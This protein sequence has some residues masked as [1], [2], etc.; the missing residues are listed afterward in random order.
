MSNYHDKRDR[1]FKPTLLGFVSLM[2]ACGTAHL[3]ADTKALTFNTPTLVGSAAPASSAV[4]KNEQPTSAPPVKTSTDPSNAPPPPSDQV[5]SRL[6]DPK[7]LTTHEWVRLTVQI[8][9]GKLTL[10]KAVP[11]HFPTPQTTARKF[12]RFEAELWIGCELIDRV[13]FDFPLLATEAPESNAKTHHPINFEAQGRFE[14]TVLLPDSERATRIELRDRARDEG[15]EPPLSFP[16]PLP[17]DLLAPNN[18]P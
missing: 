5:C 3:D 15:P 16:W 18:A 1:I 17:K 14:T 4:P 11:E 10:L 2:F 7:P 13:R 8:N 9:Q 12:G 6:P